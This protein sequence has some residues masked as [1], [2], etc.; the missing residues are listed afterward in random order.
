[1]KYFIFSILFLIVSCSTSQKKISFEGINQKAL[2]LAGAAY[3]RGCVDGQKKPQYPG[4]RFERCKKMS[5]DYKKEI[6]PILLD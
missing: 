4:P 2:E 3:L 1:M 6:S 5:V